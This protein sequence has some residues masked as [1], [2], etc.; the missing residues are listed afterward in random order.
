[1]VADPDKVQQL[2][3][4]GFNEDKAKDA[5]I[6]YNNNV[7]SACNHLVKKERELESGGIE[8]T[9]LTQQQQVL[10]KQLRVNKTKTKMRK[11]AVRVESSIE[12]RIGG[13]KTDQPSV[14]LE[15]RISGSKTKNENDQDDRT[16]VSESKSSGGMVADPD[17]VQQL[18]G[19]GF[20]EDKAK[21]ALITYNNNVESACNHLVGM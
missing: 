1:M 15:V 4:M 8:L 20:N 13:V 17:K 9:Q 3:G 18:C 14:K 6:A 19:M 10:V 11:S 12:S 16:H 2:C 7:E 5:L 21:D